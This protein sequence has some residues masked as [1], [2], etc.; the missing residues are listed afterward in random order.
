M[1]G[2][3][4]GLFGILVLIFAVKSSMIIRILHAI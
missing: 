1:T 4:D 2:P 3:F